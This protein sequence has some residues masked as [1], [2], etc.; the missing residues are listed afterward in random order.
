LFYRRIGNS[1]IRGLDLPLTR[2]KPARKPFGR[3][4]PP[5]GYPKDQSLY[6]DPENWR[7]P[8]HTSWNA[9]AARRYFDEL[10]NRA[11]Y[12]EDERAYIDW[13]IDDAL[14][15]FEQE[16]KPG[17]TGR[18][19]PR[20]PS[21]KKVG[22]LSLKEL[23][24]LFLGGARLKRAEEIDNS[25]VLISESGP[26]QIS[27]KIKEYLVQID[28]ENHRILHDC[29]DWRKNMQSKNMCKHLGKFLLILDQNTATDLLRDILRN[30]DEWTF[31]AP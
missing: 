2:K 17:V 3:N 31:T 21:R 9:K 22:E 28:L 25:L 10:S 20:P 29:Q 27:G 18:P 6:A 19:P 26:H 24:R 16:T 4:G 23:L 15:R 5:K 1:L 7:Y 11:K 30:P 14:K 12:T 13:R 8:L